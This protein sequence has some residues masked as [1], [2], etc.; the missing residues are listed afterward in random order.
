[1]L[2]TERE[3]GLSKQAEEGDG[4][5][6]D[7]PCPIDIGQNGLLMIH[8]KRTIVLVAASHVIKQLHRELAAFSRSGICRLQSYLTQ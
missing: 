4:I 3:E 7:F 8:G 1:M 5:V 2:Q 6:R